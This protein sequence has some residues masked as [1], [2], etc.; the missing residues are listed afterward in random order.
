MSFTLD[1]G[2]KAPEIVGL[3]QIE[4]PVIVLFFTS[5]NC[6]FVLGSEPL[7]KAAAETFPHAQFLAVNSNKD[8]KAE[9]QWPWPTIHDESQEIAKALGA[10]R[11]PHFF[12]FDQ[13]RKLIYTGRGV[14]DPKHPDLVSHNNLERTLE[15]HFAGQPIS[16][17]I[18]NPIG[19]TI[20]W[21]GDK[22]EGACDLI[23]L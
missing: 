4:A 21:I 14:D 11:T 12:I 8:E 18:T 6:P 10:L 20:K 15:E 19:C 13:D 3:D 2:A 16:V 5:D 7:I 17:P 22:P 9:H 23:E 1:I